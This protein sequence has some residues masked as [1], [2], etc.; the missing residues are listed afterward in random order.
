MSPAR[1]SFVF[2]NYKLCGVCWSW[3]TTVS[4][5]CK[6]YSPVTAHT[7]IWC[8]SLLIQSIV[9]FSFFFFYPFMCLSS[10][11]LTN[12]QLLNFCSFFHW[13]LLK[14]WLFYFV[15]ATLSR[16]YN[17]LFSLITLITDTMIETMRRKGKCCK[18]TSFW[19]ITELDFVINW[20]ATVPTI[21]TIYNS[22]NWTSYRWP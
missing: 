8:H 17:M 22:P 12:I 2:V 7:K 1:S 11:C 4:I 10:W 18:S 14:W 21:L 15:D 13:C 6:D 20:S 3:L 9:L 5:K 16:S 19:I